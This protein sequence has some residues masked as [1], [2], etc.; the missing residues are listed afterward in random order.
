[1]AI[2]DAG[3]RAY[4]PLPDFDNRSAFFGRRELTYD[5]ERDLYEC[6]GGEMLTLR[7]HKYT[8]RTITLARSRLGARI[9]P[10]DGR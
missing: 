1:M 9:V 4:V 6:P 8:E 7:K 2:E 5:A 3:I 10:R